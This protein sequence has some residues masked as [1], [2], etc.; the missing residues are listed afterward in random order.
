MTRVNRPDDLYRAL[1][2]ILARLHRLETGDRLHLA[3]TNAGT[4]KWKDAS[5]TDQI[6]IGQ[7]SDG[8]YAV[9]VGTSLKIQATGP[10]AGQI[11]GLVISAISGALAVSG[12]LSA[13]GGLAVTGALSTSDHNASSNVPTVSPDGVKIFV[14]TTDPGAA[15]NNG[16]IWIN[17]T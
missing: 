15:A 10:S 17:T 16:D 8:T 4:T 14:Q 1:D 5:G 12:L 3:A 7:E 13:N 11:L 2:D 9:W 6:I